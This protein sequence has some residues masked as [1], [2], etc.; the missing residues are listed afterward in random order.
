[1]NCSRFTAVAKSLLFA[2]CCL[3]TAPAVSAQPL[4]WNTFLGGTGEDSPNGVVFDASGN[5]YVVGTSYATWGTPLT[6]FGGESDAFVAKLDTDGNL[7][8]STFLGGAS[9]DGGYAID[10][11]AGGNIYVGGGSQATWG[12]P[13]SSYV[14]GAFAAK[15][16]NDGA[17]LWHTFL[18]SSESDTVLGLDVDGSGNVHVTGWSLATWGMPVSPTV[19]EADIF[20][21]KLTTD[22]ALL[23][24]TFVGGAENDFGRGISVD[25]GG[26]V[27]LVGDASATFGM[28]VRALG[29]GFD[30]LVAKL[31][32]AGT[33]LWH[34]FLGGT[35]TDSGRE[36]TLDALGNIYV[37][38][39]SGGDWGMAI[40]P[41]DEGT[42]AFAARLDADGNLAWN[43]FLGA[44]GFDDGWDIALDTA[45]NV[46]VGGD[47]RNS[48]GVPESPFAGT[49]AAF[50]AE[51]EP[52]TGVLLWNTFVGGDAVSPG[53]GLGLDGANNLYFIGY[54]TTTWGDPV[55][56]FSAS[57]DVFVARLAPPGDQQFLNI[58]SRAQVG[59]GDEIAIAGFIIR[60]EDSG[61][62]L[63]EMRGDG[64]LRTSKMSK[65]GLAL[66]VDRVELARAAPP[67]VTKQLLIRGLG[68]SLE[69]APSVPFPGRLMDP[70][71][72]L[73]NGNGDML[74][75]NDDWRDTQE[76][77]IIATGLAPTNDAEAALLVDLDSDSNYTVFLEGVS[78]TT[79]IGLVEVYDLEGNRAESHLANISTRAKVGTGDDVLIGGTII[80]GGDRGR[81][82]LRGIGPTLAAHGV[83]G[84]LQDPTLQLYDANGNSL[85]FNDDWMEAPN[86]AEIAA[87][88]LAPLDPEE[89]AILITPEAGHYTAILR[90]KNN[91][92]GIGLVE[93]Y[94][95]DP[96]PPPCGNGIIEMGETCDDGNTTSSDGCAS[97]CSVEVGYSCTG[98][99]SACTPVCGDG[100]VAGSETCDDG[101][102]VPGDGCDS[103]CTE[104][105]GFSCTGT[106]SACTA[107]CG[108][109]IV[110]G[111]E[112]CDD[113]NSVSG[114]GCDSNCSVEAGYSCTGTPSACTAICGDGIVAGAETCDDGNSVSGDGCDSSCS[115]EAG[116]SCT[117]T[118]SACTAICGDGMVTGSETCDDS[119]TVSGDGCDSNCSVEA[120][121]CGNGIVEGSEECDDGNT[122]AADGCSATCSVEEGFICIGSP[123][124]CIPL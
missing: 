80:S 59:T 2:F 102:N 39:N 41:Y 69:S 113:G 109:G 75:F 117:G 34:T 48:W 20:V 73:F 4:D 111:A 49:S 66:T 26:N 27:H 76:S 115:V 16:D 92:T 64:R 100:I 119:N 114:D 55:R 13:L 68:P 104:E 60:T 93:G 91:T 98:V 77:E 67:L 23:W 51:L 88:G 105:E 22:G 15:L 37:T 112:T 71:L 87:T 28:P 116:Y 103:N 90:G 7:V 89:S 56:A 63:T 86:S 74:A 96:L 85:L 30:V 43:T 12:M 38:G 97:V 46:F 18:G 54:S 36:L 45:G 70:T 110:A 99:P 25:G 44:A 11:D 24:N 53:R 107:I 29:G 1:M 83:P 32:S 14:G 42:D 94:R 52:D 81:L 95:L 19:G 31:N 47:S 82:L 9:S 10:L 84:P 58:S 122:D 21:A 5:A 62:C 72:Q 118:P 124:T 78:S 101:N 106:P 121:T 6:G 8:W 65:P 61:I 50:A 108:D 40:R 33:L 120:D 17:L 35:A 3:A 123:S 79:G 57:E